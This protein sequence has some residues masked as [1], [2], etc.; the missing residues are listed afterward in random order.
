MVRENEDEQGNNMSERFC[1]MVLSVRSFGSFF[2]HGQ[3]V[4]LGMME[5]D[6]AHCCRDGIPI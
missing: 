1:S 2:V 3:F 4:G 6:V 5:L